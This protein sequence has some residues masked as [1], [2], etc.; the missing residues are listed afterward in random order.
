MSGVEVHG[1]MTDTRVGYT[2]LL[3]SLTPTRYKIMPPQAIRTMPT[4]REL[5]VARQNSLQRCDSLVHAVNGHV[6]IF[7]FDAFDVLRL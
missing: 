1:V 7:S 4:S 5:Q 2:I 6:D 3:Q